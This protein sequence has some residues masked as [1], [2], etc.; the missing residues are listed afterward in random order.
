MQNPKVSVIIPL[1]SQM[2]C[3]PSK[4]FPSI[5]YVKPIPGCVE[6]VKKQDYKNVEIILASKK[7]EKGA[8]DIR[9]EAIKKATGDII[10]FI[11]SDAILVDED[12]VSKLVKVFEETDADVIIGSSIANRKVAPLFTYLLNIEYEDRERNMGEGVVEAGATTYF[13]IKKSV[14]E[15]VGGFPLD[16]ASF[17]KGNLY[18]E[19]G[20]ADWDFC[21]ILKE[22]NYKIWHTNKVKV[23]HVYQTKFWSYFKKQTI[24]SWYRVAYW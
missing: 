16:S 2:E 12:E 14:L 20:F 5:T 4:K 15:D 13:A 23:Y 17:K 24:Q 22:K 21:G 11:C 6:S 8:G 10:F 7:S 18:F 19:S 9:N 3:S 1:F